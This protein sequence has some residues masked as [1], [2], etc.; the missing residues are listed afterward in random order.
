MSDDDVDPRLEAEAQIARALQIVIDAS[1]PAPD[2]PDS[3]RDYTPEEL[4]TLFFA[5]GTAMVQ[6]KKVPG[7]RDARDRFYEKAKGTLIKRGRHDLVQA[8]EQ[9][10]KEE[11]A[12]IVRRAFG[13][14]IDL[15]PGTAGHAMV[16]M[17]ELELEDLDELRR[18]V[19]TL[20]TSMR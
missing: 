3:C 18:K 14:S 19:M 5:L 1:D 8:S 9:E 12:K 20:A 6:L 15:S 10:P 16:R 2:D 11:A 7:G 17:V 4:E 13:D